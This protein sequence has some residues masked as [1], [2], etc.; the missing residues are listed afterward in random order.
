MRVL[1]LGRLK[2]L[3]APALWRAKHDYFPRTLKLHN[4]EKVRYPNMDQ[5]V[6]LNMV[7]KEL[8]AIH[9]TQEEKIHF[10][11]FDQNGCYGSQPQP[12]AQLVTP[13]LPVGP[14]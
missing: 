1:L 14:L 9:C 12:F 2:E 7:K 6:C 13:T 5:K 11:G 8:C 4:G 3:A 10:D